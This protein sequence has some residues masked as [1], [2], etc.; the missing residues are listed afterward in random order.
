ME[1]MEFKFKWVDDEGQETGFFS[2]KGSFDG[3]NLHLDDTEI[4]VAAFGDVDV[5]SNR[6]ILSTVGEDG[7]PVYIVIA[8]TQGGAGK[9]KQAIGLA[10]SAVWAQ[11]HREELEQEGRGH[12]YR[13]ALCPHCGATLDLTGFPATDQVS[14][15]F[16]HSI[17]TLPGTSAAGDSPAALK[18]ENEHRLCDECGMYSKPRKFTIF[19]FYFLLVVYGWSQRETWRCP[20]CMRPEAWKMFFG[21]LLFVLGVPVALVQLFRAYGGADVGALYPGLDSAN[22]KARKGN[23]QGAI[24]DYQKMLQKRAVAGG[25][26]YNIGLAFLH[27]N[28]I[29]S[30]ARSFEFA[31]GDCA[32]YRPAASAL[33]GC[34]EQ[35]GETEN[36]ESLKK[37]WGV[38]DDEQEQAT[39]AEIVE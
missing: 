36:L 20:G 24:A 4:P 6:L 21:N 9:L 8:V 7:Q 37:Q 5:R 35:L 29:D 14:C 23:L 16:C 26:K 17:G 33:L 25:V 3:Q 27:D 34:Y 28:D 22:L 38:D 31:L 32:N 39:D 12:E 11:M 10:R 1:A 19:Y 2:K 30:A 18:A 13:E 15:D